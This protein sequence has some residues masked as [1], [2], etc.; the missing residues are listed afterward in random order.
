[1][2]KLDLHNVLV[3]VLNIFRVGY[4]RIEDRAI[5]VKSSPG[6]SNKNEI[7]IDLQFEYYED[8]EEVKEDTPVNKIE[9]GGI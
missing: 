7:Y 8:R 5:Q 9:I 1:M 3:N 2:D 4:M 6:G